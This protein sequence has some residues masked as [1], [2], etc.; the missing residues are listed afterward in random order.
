MPKNF[1][2]HDGRVGLVADLRS[3]SCLGLLFFIMCLRAVAISGLGNLIKVG[4]IL[5]VFVLNIYGVIY[6]VIKAINWGG[7]GG[8]GIYT[9]FYRETGHNRETGQK[10]KNK[11]MVE[12]QE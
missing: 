7:R 5:M 9:V 12:I 3:N 4:P 6:G 10:N 2:S 11:K 8:E 1:K